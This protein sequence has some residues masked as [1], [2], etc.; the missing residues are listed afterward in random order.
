MER[1]RTQTPAAATRLRRL[2]VLVAL[3]H[4]AVLGMLDR[5]G[6]P[7]M[8]TL[9]GSVRA[10]VLLAPHA[11]AH[12]PPPN[13]PAAADADLTRRSVAAPTRPARPAALRDRIA[14]RSAAAVSAQA[15]APQGSAAGTGERAPGA[16]DEDSRPPPVYPTRIPPPATLHFTAR[17]AGA[18]GP[19]ELRWQ[20]DGERYRLALTVAGAERPL[21]EQLS[22]GGFDAAGLAPTRFLD[23]RRGRSVGAAHFRRDS[24]R[25]T[26]SGPAV[27]YP[28]WAGAQDRLA[29][30]VQ[31]AA[32]FT[33]AAAPPEELRFFVAD[34]RGVARAWV[35]RAQGSET[36]QTSAGALPTLK[37]TREPLRP[38]DL[39]V[40][41]WLDPAAQ[42]WPARV[43][44]V[45]P[46]S[47]AI[48][49]LERTELAPAEAPP[50]PSGP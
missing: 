4:L 44:F 34:A 38:D 22:E 30:L 45:V 21:V 40:A 9:P 41:V 10:V 13:V 20:H 2:T 33:A 37:Y 24:G 11:T 15:T 17:V 18:E 25:I 19:A 28:A 27:E 42:G 26:F 39:R 29:W 12:Q 14:A 36:L 46:L 3:A 31:L 49:T 50:R 48:F 16:P 35:L 47:G 43:E 7:N 5:P 23:R 8:S 1:G 6:E 32:V